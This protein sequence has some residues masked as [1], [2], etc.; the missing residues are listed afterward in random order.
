MKGI[1][2]RCVAAVGTKHGLIPLRYAICNEE[3]NPAQSK[4]DVQCE[5]YLLFVAGRR[6]RED[7]QVSWSESPS[8]FIH[9]A[10]EGVAA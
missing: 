8:A 2:H 5:R 3:D 7:L 9:P 10:R 4:V 1:E 6:A